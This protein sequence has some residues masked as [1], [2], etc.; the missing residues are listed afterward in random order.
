MNYPEARIALCKCK[1]GN[2]PFGIRFEEYENEWK[3]TWAFTIKKD[4]A[5]ERENYS[6]TT[7]KG[8]IRLAIEYPGCPYCSARGFIICGDCG[9]L[10]CNM[11]DRDEVFTCG[12]CG[13]TGELTEYFG[14]GFNAGNDR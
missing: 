12:W 13:E 8:K 1:E 11:H 9:G 7:L 6:K 3:A 2:R 10:N 14:D 5:A 4:G